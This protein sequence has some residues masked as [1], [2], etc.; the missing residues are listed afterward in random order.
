MRLGSH[1]KSGNRFAQLGTS[2]GVG[3]APLGQFSA[4]FLVILSPGIV[5][6]VMEPDGQFHC[7]RLAGQMARRIKL[8]E[9]LGDVAEVVV[10]PV[11]LGVKRDQFLINRE[12]LAFGGD[13]PPELNPPVWTGSLHARAF[14]SR[15]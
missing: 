10:V 6:S 5:N 3:N 14:R 13:S 4:V 1:N 15:W 2:P 11:G 12:R 7:N 9:T 8:S